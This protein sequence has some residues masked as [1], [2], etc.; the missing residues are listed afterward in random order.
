M[1]VKYLNTVANPS[2]IIT[3]QKILHTAGT[4]PSEEQPPS[5]NPGEQRKAAL[6]P[7]S[8]MG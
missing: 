3:N 2:V 7:Q 6:T 4:C 5:P 8:T 1:R